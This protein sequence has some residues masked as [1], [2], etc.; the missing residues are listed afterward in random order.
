MKTLNGAN[1]WLPDGVER[2]YSNICAST[3]ELLIP[4][5]SCYLVKCVLVFADNF[6][7]PKRNRRD[8]MTLFVKKAQYDI[9]SIFIDLLV[10]MDIAWRF[11][12]DC[13]NYS[14]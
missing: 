1:V 6:F 5:T 4:F 14:A 8:I 13:F 2:K 10:W 12:T 11:N 7:E 3:K 9:V